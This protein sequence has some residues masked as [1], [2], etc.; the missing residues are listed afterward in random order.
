MTPNRERVWVGLF[1]VIAVA[2]LSLTAIAV[3]GGLGSSGVTHRTYFKFSGGVQ[4]GAGGDVVVRRRT[5]RRCGLGATGNRF[6]GH[7]TRLRRRRRGGRRAR[8]RRRRAAL[9]A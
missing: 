9:L 5:R 6:G 7:F 8:P 3:W 4:S 2:V 1:V